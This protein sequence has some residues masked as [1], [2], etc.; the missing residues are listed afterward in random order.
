MKNRFLIVSGLS[1]AG[2]TV[3]LHAL[4][5]FGF[6]C[7]DNLPIGFLAPFADEV[8]R[9]EMPHY[10]QVA[11]GIDARSP[12]SVLAG[13]PD[14]LK[15][16]KARPINA[17]LIFMQ[18]SDAVLIQ[19]FSETRRRHPLSADDITLPKALERERAM[20]EPMRALADLCIDTTELDVHGLREIVRVQIAHRATGRMAI[21]IVSFGYKNGIPPDADFVFDMR[22]LPNPH[23]DPALRVLTGRDKAV[24]EYLERAPEVTELLAEMGALLAKWLPR[25][26]ARDRSYLTIALGCTGGRHRS[27]YMAEALAAHLHSQ[28]LNCLIRHRDL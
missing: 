10:R 2:K 11:I 3:V 18:S 5:D 1:G 24:C 28:R 8:E 25:F 7:V 13:L 16:L 22:C 19:R 27:V 12:M 6:Y 14:L 15:Q 23:W 20:L 4:E 21:Q 17:E 26:E 9:G